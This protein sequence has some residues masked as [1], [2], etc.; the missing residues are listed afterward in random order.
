VELKKVINKYYMKK[1]LMLIVLGLCTHMLIA[2]QKTIEIKKKRSECFFGVHFDFHADTGSREIGKNFSVSLIDSMLKVVKPDFIQVDCKGHPGFS[3]YP[4]HVGNPAPGFVRDPLKIWRSETKKYGVALYVHYSGIWD[5]QICKTHPSWAAVGSDGKPDARAT[6]VFGPYVD[7]L[8]IPQMK[9]LITR[10]DID[11]AWVDGDCWGMT[12]DYSP[13]AIEAYKKETGSSLI[14]YKPKDPDYQKYVSF[15]RTGFKNYVRHYADAL[16]KINPDF[17]FT[18]NWAF[19]SRMPEP[20][21]LPLDYLSGDLTPQNS[22]SAAAFEAR[23]MSLQGKPW[24]LMS[25][26][27]S[28]DQ[29]KISAYKSA[30]Q[31]KQEAAEVI[32]M[33]GGFQV[34]FSQNRDASIN[35]WYIGTLKELSD[36]CKDRKP[37]CFKANPIAQIALIHSSQGFFN[38]TKNVYSTW[39]FESEPIKGVLTALLDGQNIVKIEREYSIKGNLHNY[40][41]VIYPDWEVIAPDFKE[42]LLNYVKEGGNLIVIGAKTTKLFEDELGVKFSGF[43]SDRS[44]NLFYKGMSGKISGN[45]QGVEILNGT[46]SMGTFRGNTE[47]PASSI[48]IYGKGKIAGI[49]FDFGE[50]Y[51]NQTLSELRIFLDDIVK[52]IFTNPIVEVTGSHL[53]HVALNELNGRLMINLIN[54][55]GSHH[56]LRVFSYDQVPPVG[57]VKLSINMSQKPKSI[58]LQPEDIQLKFRYENN[59]VLLEIPK[60]EIHSIIEIEK[61]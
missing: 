44:Q 38:K 55:A 25:W 4:T 2:Q 58:R 31:L 15:I 36:F 54:T 24:D 12:V 57:P 3:S 20:V 40:P 22:L 61:L 6:S 14:P 35:D 56:D 59:K 26:G 49:Y 42:E 37:F 48:C 52:R 19:S 53:V 8:F 41:L 60:I 21:S 17:Q 28:S 46:E 43:I 10:Y 16:H 45:L 13:K 27:F 47:M 23:C 34:Y 11:G 9:E 33:G 30:I 18:S 5:Y 39:Q 32:S 50:A 7:S 29:T 1:I 51:Q